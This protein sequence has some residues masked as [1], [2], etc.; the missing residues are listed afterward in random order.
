MLAEKLMS[1]KDYNIDE[2]I[3]NIELLKI[4]FGETALQTCNIIVRDV[5]DSKRLDKE[6]HALQS[7]VSQNCPIKLSQMNCLAVSK[8]YWPINYEASNSHVPEVFKE[9]F[10]EYSYNFTKKKA[11]RKI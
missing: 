1:A 5:K 11:M 9:V 8:G 4:R 3:K 10:D 2:E 6:I 7:G